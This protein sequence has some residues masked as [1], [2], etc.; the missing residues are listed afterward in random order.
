MF[1]VFSLL[2][3]PSPFLC[4]ALF[5]LSPS[6]FSSP[7]SFPFW[8][9]I[10][11]FSWV[12]FAIGLCLTPFKNVLSGFFR[13]FL[14]LNSFYTWNKPIVSYNARFTSPIVSKII[15]SSFVN[16]PDSAS[17][18]D[19]HASQV[20]HASQCWMSTLSAGHLYK[21]LNSI[22]SNTK[23]RLKEDVTFKAELGL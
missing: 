13:D 16:S 15:S 21:A 17:L 11:Y 10:Q 2:F 18:P 19:P 1:H 23:K 4:S 20:M 12:L 8:F 5:L 14:T 22:P 9:W 3:S 6:S 7:L